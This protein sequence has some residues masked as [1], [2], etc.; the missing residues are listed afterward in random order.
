MKG[1]TDRERGG[2]TAIPRG[3]KGAG[4]ARNIR[5]YPRVAMVCDVVS[6]VLELYIRF[7]A[8]E[9][10]MCKESWV[11]LLDIT[12]PRLKVTRSRQKV[13]TAL[14][15]FPSCC[16]CVVSAVVAMVRAR[17]KIVHTKPAPGSGRVPCEAFVRPR[18]NHTAPLHDDWHVHEQCTTAAE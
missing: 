6:D 5:Q 16:H 14:S 3:R 1:K 7:R 4:R 13:E 18:S 15:S 2:E 10:G 17:S 12:F 8:K 9:E 11:E